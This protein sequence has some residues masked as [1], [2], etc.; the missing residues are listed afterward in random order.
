MSTENKKSFW[1]SII[2]ESIIPSQGNNVIQPYPN[3]VTVTTAA[4]LKVNV[5]ELL[6][7]AA[8]KQQIDA[9]KELKELAD[10]ENRKG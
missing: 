4:D 7:T 2:P 9:L 5:A 10:L 8:A 1:E 6:R 3:E